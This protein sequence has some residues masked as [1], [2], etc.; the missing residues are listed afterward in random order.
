MLTV[1][2]SNALPRD[3]NMHL[4]VKNEAIHSFTCFLRMASVQDDI[5]GGINNKSK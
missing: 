4:Q 5:T 1:H 3:I 2:K